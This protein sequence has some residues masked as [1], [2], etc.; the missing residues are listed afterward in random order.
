MILI[1]NNTDFTSLL[2]SF[3]TYEERALLIQNKSLFSH[4]IDYYGRFDFVKTHEPLK[5][6][7]HLIDEERSKIDFLLAHSH[8]INPILTEP[9][10]E[11]CAQIV[12]NSTITVL[13]VLHFCTILHSKDPLFVALMRLIVMNPN[14]YAG[15]ADLVSDTR[16]SMPDFLQDQ[17]HQLFSL[18]HIVLKQSEDVAAF[19]SR[20]SMG[21]IHSAILLGI[22]MG[23]RGLF[24]F[25]SHF[26]SISMEAGLSQYF[27]RYV[28][29]LVRLSKVEAIINGRQ[30]AVDLL[31]LRYRRVDELFSF[32]SANDLQVYIKYHSALAHN[33]ILLGKFDPFLQQWKKI[34]ELKWSLAQCKQVGCTPIHLAL[35]HFG[36]G[37]Y[38]QSAEQMEALLH[39]TSLRSNRRV[40]L[41]ILLH[42][43]YM[44]L[45][46]VKRAAQLLTKDHYFSRFPSIR[47]IK[48]TDYVNNSTNLL[49]VYQRYQRDHS[50]VWLLNRECMTISSEN[51]RTCFILAA[52]YRS[53]GSRDAT[54]L[55]RVLHHVL[56]H[57]IERHFLFKTQWR[58]YEVYSRE[59]S[60][61]VISAHGRNNFGNLLVM[62]LFLVCILCVAALG[63]AV[64]LHL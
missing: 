4:F 29:L 22:D 30:K 5:E 52:F 21:D 19:Q 59:S 7:F 36:Q 9:L 39:S 62:A 43:S 25:D 49:I 56:R 24:E 42:E 38:E 1:L 61:P 58:D 33:Y 31:M 53:L 18:A 15:S 46:D 27:E 3:F 41:F 64:I 16:K 40:Q 55:G 48:A 26:K 51:Y 23:Q 2:K 13:E 10:I 57:H 28:N 17:Q 47:T 45:G 8:K 50:I 6:V 54:K 11:I 44:R 37:D 35:A 63:C 32:T 14:L 20:L 60:S 34:I 12:F